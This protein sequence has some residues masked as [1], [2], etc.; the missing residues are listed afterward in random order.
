[1]CKYDHLS[2]LKSLLDTGALTQDEFAAAKKRI[3]EA[4]SP[5]ELSNEPEAIP[6][7]TETVRESGKSTNT[8]WII[9]VAAITV[10]VVLIV[11]FASSG[12]KATEAP[13][14]IATPTEEEQQAALEEIFADY[15][16]ESFEE[17]FESFNPWHVDYFT[18]EW[19]EPD[20]SK[21]MLYSTI[22]D[23]YWGI[24]IQYVP[25][26][27]EI[28][29]DVFRFLVTQNGE[30]ANAYGPLEILFRGADGETKRVDVM[31]EMDYPAYVVE[32]STVNALKYYLNHEEFDLRINFG[33]WNERHHAQGRWTSTPG[34][35][36]EAINK[37]L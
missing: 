28:P 1:M 22:G 16:E 11:I 27:E 17:Q 15:P 33:I 5:S 3:L 37:L 29:Q 23:S 9:L 32:P 30:I 21:P 12:E 26:T 8:K 4:G 13:E 7:S 35:F 25:A 24:R 2:Q 20:T 6:E 31:N 19:G 18:N 14:Y 34:F 36:Q 10:I